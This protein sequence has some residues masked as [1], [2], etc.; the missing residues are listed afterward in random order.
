MNQ[1]TANTQVNIKTKQNQNNIQ[2][3]L[4]LIN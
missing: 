3:N 1:H 2:Y 4:T